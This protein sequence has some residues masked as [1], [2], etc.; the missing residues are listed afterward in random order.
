MQADLSEE[1][2]VLMKKTKKNMDALLHGHH[3]RVLVLRELLD[4]QSSDV[5]TIQHLRLK[6]GKACL[7]MCG[8][9][10]VF[11][12]HM[13]DAVCDLKAVMLPNVDD[14][15]EDAQ[16]AIID[17]DAGGGLQETRF[18][19]F[20]GDMEAVIEHIDEFLVTSRVDAPKLCRLYATIAYYMLADVCGMEG[21]LEFLED[22]DNVLDG[23]AYNV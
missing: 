3:A 1:P 14:A 13:H 11:V 12:E 7:E 2:N 5:L 17:S 23:I 19:D 21:V 16:D 20:I 10:L 9:L 18:D 8:E 15:I 6:V 4:M 22:L